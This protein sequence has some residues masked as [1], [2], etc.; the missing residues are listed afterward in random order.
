MLF[1]M[2]LNVLMAYVKN[3]KINFSITFYN[4][5]KDQ[6]I[7]DSILMLIET[8]LGGLKELL[9]TDFSPTLD[10]TYMQLKVIYDENDDGD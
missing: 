4:V 5:V 1:M 8:L 9:D 7:S 2:N 10:S 6:T 3:C